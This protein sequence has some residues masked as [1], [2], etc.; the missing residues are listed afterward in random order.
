MNL[1]TIL[2]LKFPEADMSKDIIVQDD[3]QGPYIAKW[4]VALGAKPTQADLDLLA[5]ELAPVKQ[6]QDTR[7]NRRNEYPAMGDQLD[8]LYKAM[9]SGVLPKVVEFYDSIKAVKDKHPL[10]A[11]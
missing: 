3:G 5:I 11:K 1:S 8:M 4:D 7:Q 6:A 9:D 10:G 2:K